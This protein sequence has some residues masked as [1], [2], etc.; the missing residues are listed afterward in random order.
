MID[1]ADWPA[2]LDFADN[3]RLTLLLGHNC[4]QHL[5]ATI[6]ARIDANLEANRRRVEGLST[7]YLEIAD[8]LGAG[9]VD[10]VLLKG[11]L[12]A[13]SFISDVSLRQQYDIDLLV[14]PQDVLRARVLI[15]D[16][17]YEPAFGPTGYPTDHLPPLVRKTGWQWRG[18]FF[19]P[20][21]PTTVELH[22]R[23]WD[24][25]TERFVVGGLDQYWPRRTLTRL[26]GH[27]VPTLS[28]ADQLGHAALHLVLYLMLGY[29]TPGYMYELSYVFEVISENENF[30]KAWAAESTPSLRRYKSMTFGLARRWFGC[31]LHARVEQEIA[32][33]P[34]GLRC[35]SS[36]Y[37]MA[38]IEALFRPNKDGLWLHLALLPRF[39]D[40][41]LV[42]RRRL[43]PLSAP[44]PSDT[45]FVP[46]CR[47][48]ASIRLRTAIRYAGFLMSRTRFMAYGWNVTRVA[49]PTTSRCSIAPSARSRARP[50]APR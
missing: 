40:R 42:V 1:D 35:W 8:H 12:H 44:C 31:R 3:S 6:A 46:R 27:R 17:G 21:M 7:D 34:L 50:T 41:L 22:F 29:V 49:M 2:A 26:R 48:T 28:P 13:P 4:R 38:P 5:P 20:E 24:E 43:I 39:S 9:E 16:M 47:Q 36:H 32:Q 23:L 15:E 11:F 45:M 37:A 33:C 10:Q 14:Q 18:E 19:D 25:E 30:W